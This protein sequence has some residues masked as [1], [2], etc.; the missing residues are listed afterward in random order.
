MPELD[1]CLGDVRALPLADECLDGYL[2][3]GVIEHFWDG[4]D[5]ILA[6]MQRTIRP[7]G[8]LVLSFPYM[9]PLRRWKVSLQAYPTRTKGECEKWRHA[10][11]QFALPD[12]R[13]Q[14]DLERLGFRLVERLTYN[15]IKGFKD[16]LPWL[17]RWLQPIYDG[18][19]GRRLRAPMEK[20][21][22]PLA[23]H[24]AL[25]VMQ[26]MPAGSDQSPG[27]PADSSICTHC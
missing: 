25:L 24:S 3:V 15:G 11:Y 5:R 2:S 13:V 9:S 6:E 22:R 21:L 23:S 17:K 4:Y 27:A 18:K 10:F 20:L 8:F 7:A 14:R 1:V 16:E 26:K 19:R 12:A